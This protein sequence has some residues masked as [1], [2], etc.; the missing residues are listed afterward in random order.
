[1]SLLTC[2]VGLI[3]SKCF[4]QPENVGYCMSYRLAKK[5][6]E[7]LNSPRTSKGHIIVNK[8]VLSN[9]NLRSFL[10]PPSWFGSHAR[11]PR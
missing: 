5:K 7:I 3:Q 6:N 2:F 10:N 8:A 9:M 1:M 11:A 4:K